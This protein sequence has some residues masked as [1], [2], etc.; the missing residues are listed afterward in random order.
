MSSLEKAEN[1]FKLE[2][3]KSASMQ[4][5]EFSIPGDYPSL[6]Q[7]LGRYDKHH[8]LLHMDANGNL[9]TYALIPLTYLVFLILVL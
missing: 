6:D 2:A 7:E 8:P 9:Y 4:Q 3:L 5:E 1:C